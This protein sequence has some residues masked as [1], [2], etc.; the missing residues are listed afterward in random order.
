ME[1]LAKFNI[2]WIIVA[3]ILFICPSTS[4]SVDNTYDVIIVGAGMLVYI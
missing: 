2:F 3:V 4:Q 1:R